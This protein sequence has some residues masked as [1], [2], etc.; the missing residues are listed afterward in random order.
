L[1]FLS[2]DVFG[3]FA[4]DSTRKR[5]LDAFVQCIDTGTAPACGHAI[6]LDASSLAA[7]DATW[8]LL[9]AQAA[10]GHIDLVAHGEIDG[11]RHGWHYRPAMGDYA[12][13]E[14]AFGTATRLTLSQ[15]I[16]S[17][18]VLTVVGVPPGSGARLGI[19]RDLDATAD[20]D[21]PVPSLDLG[22]EADVPRLSWPAGHWWMVLERNQ[23]L[24]AG[25]WEAVNHARVTTGGS[26]IL[27]DFGAGPRAFFRLR[28]P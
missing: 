20:L 21:E 18:S 9:E 5:N 12:P 6:T 13:D 23:S 24:D 15:K 2:R 27:L 7:S 19:D 8:T 28:R 17:G 11:R 25:S 26:V 1:T 3:L 10:A 16:A 4:N 22:F 14:S